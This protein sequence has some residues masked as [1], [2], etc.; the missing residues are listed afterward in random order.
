[1]GGV[2]RRVEKDAGRK[3]KKKKN[4]GEDAVGGSGDVKKRTKKLVDRGSQLKDKQERELGKERGGGERKS[5][6]HSHHE[7]R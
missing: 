2:G 1:L 3:V 6:K 4:V 5:A 7:T